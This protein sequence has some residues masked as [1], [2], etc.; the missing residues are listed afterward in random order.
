MATLH[1]LLF[2][3]TNNASATE[4]PNCATTQVVD[5]MDENS[6]V[7][8]YRRHWWCPHVGVDAISGGHDKAA[9]V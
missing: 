4:M 2:H 7:M 1:S 9:G 6:T 8:S 5:N 3:T